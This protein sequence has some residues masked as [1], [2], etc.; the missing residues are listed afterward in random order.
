MVTLFV[1]MRQTT[2]SFVFT[3][4]ILHCADWAVDSI[5]FTVRFPRFANPLNPTVDNTIPVTMPRM[6]LVMIH[7]LQGS[8]FGSSE[9]VS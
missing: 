8:V 5:R 6:N 2:S 3:N 4:L 1:K 9:M 7:R